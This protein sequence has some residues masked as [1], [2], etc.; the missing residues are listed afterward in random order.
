M[1][2]DKA[3]QHRGTRPFRYAVLVLLVALAALLWTRIL[4]TPP[5]P[6]TPDAPPGRSRDNPIPCTLSTAALK[7]MAPV[8][9]LPV[10]PARELDGLTRAQ[11]LDLR[12]QAVRSQPSLAGADYTPSG[13]VFGRVQDGLPWWGVEG[14]FYHGPGQRSIEGV[15]EETR[16]ILNPYLLIYADFFG[17]SIWRDRQLWDV[18]KVARSGKTVADLPLYPPVGTLVWD[19]VKAEMTATYDI[20]AYLEDLNRYTRRT[21]G[22]SDTDLM[23]CGINAADLGLEFAFIDLRASSHMDQQQRHDQVVVLR[24]FIHKG[25]SCQYRGGCNNGSPYQPELDHLRILS[26][27]ATLRV[28][29]WDARPRDSAAPA[30]ATFV[31]Q[32]Q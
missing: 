20:T 12:R 6:D 16:M 22:V 17:L 2:G 8:I 4:L 13:Q 32:F 5:S 11:V 21:L 31:M 24:D 7:A 1:D 30:D 14:M 28:K 25:G 3:R 10:A 26:L 29:L 19:S 15:S 23:L 9:H 18:G 27:P